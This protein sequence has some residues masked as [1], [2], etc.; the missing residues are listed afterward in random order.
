MRG[1]MLALGGMLAPIHAIIW[2]GRGYLV[3]RANGLVFAGASVEDVG[4]RPRT[5]ERGLAR[6]RRMARELVP[7]FRAAQVMF[8]WAGLRP[9]SA[10]QRPIIGPLPGY[11][12]VA[13]ASGHFRNGILLGP[14]TG[15]LVAQALMDG[16]WPA[17]LS[18]FAPSRFQADA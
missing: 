14:L 11:E 5:T 8:S 1:Q 15:E 9:G 2:S 18:P 12:N 7:Q 10:D 16:E 17:Q 3:P 13:V 4:F 6:L